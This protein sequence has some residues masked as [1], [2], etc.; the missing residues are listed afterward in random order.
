MWWKIF[1]HLLCDI[2]WNCISMKTSMLIM[3][4]LLVNVSQALVVYIYSISRI[5]ISIFHLCIL[6]ALIRRRIIFTIGRVH[7]PT[8][9]R[10]P[11]LKPVV[12]PHPSNIPAPLWMTRWAVRDI[13]APLQDHQAP[14]NCKFLRLNKS[15][16]LKKSNRATTPSRLSSWQ[17]LR[18]LSRSRQSL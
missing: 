1:T 16:L 14:S 11:L 5:F 18:S 10:V 15:C 9:Q 13:P 2:M 7:N 8:E 6:L 17:C 4:H 3:L 12:P